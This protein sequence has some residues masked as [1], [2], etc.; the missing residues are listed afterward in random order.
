MYF[1]WKNADV[2]LPFWVYL[3]ATCDCRPRTF[4]PFARCES[5]HQYDGRSTS[6]T[7]HYWASIDSG[8]RVIPSHPPMPSRKTERQWRSS[9]LTKIVFRIH[10]HYFHCLMRFLDIAPDVFLPS[11]LAWWLEICFLSWFLL[12]KKDC[13][14]GISL[15]FSPNTQP[16]PSTNSSHFVCSVSSNSA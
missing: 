9:L 3:I 15:K 13:Y 1:L 10:Y 2:S 14:L 12:I 4:H 6:S 8:N 16:K 11:G 5:L 7:K